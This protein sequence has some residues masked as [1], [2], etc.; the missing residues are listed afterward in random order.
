MPAV[1]GRTLKYFIRKGESAKRLSRRTGVLAVGVG[2]ILFGPVTSMKGGALEEFGVDILSTLTIEAVEYGVDSGLN[3][4]NDPTGTTGVLMGLLGDT[5]TG[6]L[7]KISSQITIAQNMITSLQGD[8]DVFENQVTSDL[9]FIALQNAKEQYSQLITTA[10]ADYFKLISLMGTYSNVVSLCFTNNGTNRMLKS[11]LS[12]SELAYFTRFVTANGPNTLQNLPD[13]VLSDMDSLTGTGNGQNNIYGAALAELQLQVPFQHQTYGSMYK[14]FNYITA[15]RAMA[16]YLKKEYQSYQW[17]QQTNTSLS[18]WMTWYFINDFDGS[19]LTTEVNNIDADVANNPIIY[20]MATLLTNSVA[21]NGTQRLAYLYG[22]ITTNYPFHNGSQLVYEVICNHNQYTY[23]IPQTPCVFPFTITSGWQY[24][25]F[26]MSTSDGRFQ[27]EPDVTPTL[28]DLFT[29]GLAPQADP[30]DFLTRVGGL[31]NIPGGVNGVMLSRAEPLGTFAQ[32]NNQLLYLLDAQ[33]FNAGDN[34]AQYLQSGNTNV[35]LGAVV[36]SN[37]Y[38][39]ANGLTT[40]LNQATF[41]SFYY[42]THIATLLPAIAP[43]VYHPFASLTLGSLVS[44]TTGDVLDLSS[45]FGT[46]NTTIRVCGDA[47]IIGAGP[48]T[49]LSGLTIQTYGGTLTISNLFLSATTNII[50][51]SSGPLTLVVLGT[52]SLQSPL[53]IPDYYGPPTSWSVY[54]APTFAAV[55][56]C[57]QYCGGDITFTGPGSLVVTT[58]STNLPAV[59]TAGNIICNGASNLTFSSR[60]ATSV[61]AGPTGNN[62]YSQLIIV[63]SKVTSRVAIESDYEFLARTVTLG[64]NVLDMS[65]GTINPNIISPCTWLGPVRGSSQVTVKTDSSNDSGTGANIYL[66]IIG[67]TGTT[68]FQNIKNLPGGGSHWQD[69]DEDAFTMTYSVT[70]TGDFQGLGIIQAI[71]MYEDES[72]SKPAWNCDW[73][74]ITPSVIGD[75]PATYHFNV[76]HDFTS[77]SDTQTVA[78]VESNIYSYAVNPDNTNTVTITGYTGTN[79]AVVIPASIHGYMVTSIAANVFNGKASVVSVTIPA[80]VTNIGYA[81]FCACSGLREV[82]FQGSPPSLGSSVFDYLNATVNY[83]PGTTGWGTTFGTLPTA[84]W[85]PFTYYTNSDNA[86]VTITGYTGLGGAVIVPGTINGLPVTSIIDRLWPY[87]EYNYTSLTSVT[88]PGSV[89]YLDLYALSSCPI[90]MGIY[91]QGNPPSLTQG[92]FSGDLLATVY[93]LPTPGTPG[94]GTT[95]GGLPTALWEPFT[96]V[97][98]SDNATV[99]ITGYTGPGGTVTIPDTLNGLPV[100]CIGTNAFTSNAFYSSLQITNVL[101]PNTV[102]NLGDA[103]FQMCSNLAGVYF[104]GNTPSLGMNVFCSDAMA[105]AYYLPAT[106]NWSTALGILPTAL[107][108]TVNGGADGGAYPDLQ[109]VTIIASNPIAPNGQ[110]ATFVQWLGPTQYVAVVGS[111]STT[112]NLPA[113]PITLTAMFNL[114]PIITAQPA[115]QSVNNGGYGVFNV[116]AYGP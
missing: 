71:Q 78:A 55:I 1:A 39:F 94:W 12:P 36:H 83:L 109:Q 32:G 2:L 64:N 102:T 70:G 82:Y 52:N 42:D 63:N 10:N 68:T 53:D 66:R 15:E 18:Q 20:K 24:L 33:G 92:A 112:V 48:N 8:L 49:T 113:Q 95:F 100:T 99:T 67:T 79:G 110:L 106:T 4:I 9:N 69:G 16:L 43:G 3:A 31:T 54:G 72:G 62:S 90:L 87:S 96:C 5:T 97:T 56:G 40:P 45:L 84:S 29:L 81:A 60:S 13:T 59:G 47:T 23:L 61:Q 105:T 50:Y 115:S 25:D 74:T 51:N 91:F 80:S 75:V 103:A 77:A 30:L 107:W 58:S 89:T 108:L 11:N 26:T 17:S 19:G 85:V 14:L 7:D 86:S 37:N 111:A 104:Q 114:P 35:S 93:Y 73:V 34:S 38:V 116:T 57:Q 44:L 21:T 98:N 22:L 6:Q 65:Y 28:V 46:V 27:L 41:L 76:N 101:I 88:I